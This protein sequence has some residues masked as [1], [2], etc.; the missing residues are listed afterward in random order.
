MRELSGRR[1]DRGGMRLPPARPKRRRIYIETIRGRVSFRS[2]DRTELHTPESRQTGFSGQLWP[3][4]AV[5]L[6][7]RPNRPV[8]SRLDFLQTIV[9]M[10]KIILFD[11]ISWTPATMLTSSSMNRLPCVPPN[12]SF[13]MRNLT[14]V[15]LSTFLW[16]LSG[17][18]AL[19]LD[20]SD[21]PAGPPNDAIMASPAE[22]AD[23]A[24]WV[25]SAFKGNES[26]QTSLLMS[27]PVRPSLS[28]LTA[29]RRPNF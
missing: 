2:T 13:V 16:L 21:V 6:A 25:S 4:S 27:M 28:C 10:R 24:A 15:L 7:S 20:L 22:M 19:A 23:M 26:R 17:S 1:A 29:G 18:L 9:C 5:R 8:C 12:G 11:L 14:S 3:F